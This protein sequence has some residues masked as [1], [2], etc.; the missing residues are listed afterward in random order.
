MTS[1]QSSDLEGGL[2][3]RRAFWVAYI[4]LGFAVL[5]GESLAVFG[6][7]QLT[8]EGGHRGPLSA[9][10]L[11]SVVFSLGGIAIAGP[12]AAR[13]WRATFSLTMS[14]LSGLVLAIC[15]HLDSGVDSPLLYLAALPVISAALALPSMS[16]LIAGV[17]AA[18]EFAAVA[19]SEPRSLVSGDQL[20]ALSS[21]LLGVIVFTVVAARSRTRLEAH[22][23]A[24][25][26][27]LAE[28]ADRD[29]LTGCLNH[30]VFNERLESEVERAR[31]YD[32]PL[33]LLMIDVDLFKAY[34][35]SHGHAAGDA[36]LVHIA[37]VLTRTVRG[38]D[39]VARIGG[40]EFAVILPSTPLHDDAGG[41]HEVARRVVEAVGTTAENELS[42]SVGVASLDAS[43]STALRL[44]RDAD[45]ALYR[46]KLEG[47]HRVATAPG[48]IERA[49]TSKDAAAE[50]G[51][52]TERAE[53]GTI[54]GSE[55]R[56]D[57]TSR[58]TVTA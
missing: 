2:E 6:Y 18:L 47:R 8:P 21:F 53:G 29:S 41:A 57:A 49:A 16:V 11:V 12:V 30:R 20:L 10:A 43:D 40:D 24:M 27:R 51:S 4:R 1:S 5:A 35:D 58:P 13:A 42:I 7:C 56:D 31:R 46:A 25:V 39:L 54:E 26:A 32:D 38:S 23:E 15:A 52:A 37:D 17:A 55:P 34:N 45:T 28:L 3:Q 19:L 36:A 44:F 50:P 14:L 33:S 48:P 9:I 22:E